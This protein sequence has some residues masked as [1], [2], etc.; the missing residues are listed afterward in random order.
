MKAKLPYISP[1]DNKALGFF[2]D[3]FFSYLDYLT[4]TPEKY[5]IYP[6][7]GASALVKEYSSGFSSDHFTP[8]LLDYMGHQAL[9]QNVGGQIILEE[10][11]TW[12]RIPCTISG[13][14]SAIQGFRGAESTEP[15][16][17]LASRPIRS[18][19]F[20]LLSQVYKYISDDLGKRIA[21]GHIH[22]FS[23]PLSIFSLSKLPLRD[24]H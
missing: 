24:P 21:F 7:Q 3:M 2:E 18:Y 23:L 22:P 6:R 15:N 13:T 14:I 12:D 10:C 9:K 19:H 11:P 5:S 4:K 1:Y 20:S 8:Y 17:G 16:I